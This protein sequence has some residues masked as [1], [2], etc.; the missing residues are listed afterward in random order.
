MAGLERIDQWLIEVPYQG[1]VDWS[2]K[3][4]EWWA[5]NAALAMVV[6]AWVE[7]GIRGSVNQ[8][9]DLFIAVVMSIFAA[10]VIAAARTK[11][12]LSRLLCLP[13]VRHMVLVLTAIGTL[14]AMLHPDSMAFLTHA[15]TLAYVSIFYF[16][17]CR[18][19]RPRRR[20]QMQVARLAGQQSGLQ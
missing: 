13:V 10:L 4:R 19:P 7:A 5:E 11:N 20:K 17:A 12:G 15:N 16:A 1:M 18:P 8:P 6:S 3:T 9:F 2:G 14:V